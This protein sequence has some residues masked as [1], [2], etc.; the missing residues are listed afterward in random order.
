MTA[1]TLNKEFADAKARTRRT[2]FVSLILHL[3]LFSWLILQYHSSPLP[4]GIVEIAWV[5]PAPPPPPQVQVSRQVEQVQVKPVAKQK[6]F[7]RQAEQAELAPQPQDVRVRQDKMSERLASIRQ[8][9]PSRSDLAVAT[10]SSASL[11]PS[12]AVA[13]PTPQSGAGPQELVREKTR[14][15]A[16]LSLKRGP[17][18]P[19]RAAPAV[20]PLPREIT[21][22]AVPVPEVENLTQRTLEGASLAGPVADRPVVSYTMPAYPDWAARE[23]VEASVTLYFLVLPDG[24]V[25]ENIQIQKTAGFTDFDQS[26]IAALRQWRFEALTGGATEDQWGTITFHFRLRDVQ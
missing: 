21:A 15:T 11:L 16:P 14:T 13:V 7:E 8:S 10:V 2:V 23:A 4:E 9:R 5:D 17:A 26:A 1:Y 19:V 3:L 20:A 6:K 24:R 18:R 22:T 12:A 25:K